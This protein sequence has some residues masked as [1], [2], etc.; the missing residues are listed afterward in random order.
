MDTLTVWVCWASC[1]VALELAPLPSQDWRR[2][3][4]LLLAI[5]CAAAAREGAG[6]RPRRGLSAVRATEFVVAAYFAAVALV[7]LALPQA[8][9][10]RPGAASPGTTKTM[11]AVVA[12]FAFLWSD[13]WSVPLLGLRGVVR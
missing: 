6:D 12:F 4:Q 7:D 2:G 9:L 10:S 3:A 1:T 5:T 13:A 8:A 11:V